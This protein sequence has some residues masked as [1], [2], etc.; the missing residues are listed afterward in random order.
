MA[1]TTNQQHLRFIPSR[2]EG[3][4]A[5]SEAIVFPDRLDLLANGKSVVIRFAQI[6]RWPRFGVI[7]GPL[8][9]LGIV[10]GFACVADRDWFHMPADRFFRFFT[11]PA[12]TVFMPHEPAS[13]GYANSTFCKVNTM[14]MSG[15]YATMDLG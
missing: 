12:I 9:R 15:G 7:W 6:A 8:A 3:L 1:T 11:E 10:R 14:I 13:L 4:A 2:V 5:V